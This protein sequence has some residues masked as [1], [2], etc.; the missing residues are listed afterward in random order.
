MRAL[1]RADETRAVVRHAHAREEAVA[2]VAAPVRSRVVLG[3]DPEGRLALTRDYALLLP[4]LERGLGV[5]VGIA[6]VVGLREVDLDDIEGAARGE[7]GPHLGVDDVVRRGRDGVERP[8]RAG[9]VAKGS[10]GL[11]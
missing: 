4:R 10:E 2:G 8:D 6:P 5:Q 9:L 1:V 11:D 7:L 3:Q